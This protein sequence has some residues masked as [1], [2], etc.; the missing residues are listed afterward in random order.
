[1]SDQGANSIETL[2]DR[3]LDLFRQIDKL[4]DGTDP[5]DQEEEETLPPRHKTI[6]TE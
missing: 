2:W 3:H 1:M 6:K 4:V 5:T